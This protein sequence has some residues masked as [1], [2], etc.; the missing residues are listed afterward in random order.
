M[1]KAS[2]TKHELSWSAEISFSQIV[3]RDI[4]NQRIDMV[5]LTII[6]ACIAVFCLIVTITPNTL[7]FHVYSLSLSAAMASFGWAW[8]KKN[9]AIIIS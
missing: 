1:D 7:I 3:T 4:E 8:D 9:S 5:R 2:K 6:L